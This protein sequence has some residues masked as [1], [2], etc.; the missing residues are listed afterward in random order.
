MP[1]TSRP[2]QVL[3][4]AAA[5]VTDL[6]RAVPDDRW[7]RPTPC[8][9]WDVRALV[10]HLTAEHLWAPRL[11][12]GES[13]AEVGDD[14]AGDVLGDDPVAVWHHAVTTSLL[15]WADVAP[16]DELREIEV[17]S[18]PITLREYADQMLVDLVVHAWD[19]AAALGLPHLPVAEAVHRATEYERPR[20]GHGQGIDGLFR[21]AVPTTSTDP[22]DRL[23]AMLGR[24]PG[25]GA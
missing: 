6:V 24:D 7:R 16:E 12:A 5:R 15:A 18:G 22:L 1:D 19:L 17:S 8:E 14:Y 10:N 13:L 11:L 9:G 3:P 23:V 25:W 20:T 21:P 4:A 2:F